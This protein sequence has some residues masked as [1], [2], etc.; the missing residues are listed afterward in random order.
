MSPRPF[1]TALYRKTDD[2]KISTILFGVDDCYGEGEVNEAL[3]ADNVAKLEALVR[4]GW[5]MS[6]DGEPSLFES[7]SQEVVV[8]NTLTS[9]GETVDAG[10]ITSEQEF[11]IFI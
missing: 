8:Y 4:F 5:S 7:P 2:G 3:R 6:P 9:E 10:P 11:S 1:P